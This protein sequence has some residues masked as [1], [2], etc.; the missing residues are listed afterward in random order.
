MLIHFFRERIKPRID[1]YQLIDGYFDSL[2]NSNIKSNDDEV[3]IT[4]TLRNFDFQYKFFVTKRSHIL[5]IYRLNSNYININLMCEVPPILPPYISRLIFKQISEICERFELAIYFEQLDN[6]HEFEMFELINASKKE[7]A[8]YLEKNPELV[9]YHLPMNVLN[10]MCH[11]QSMIDY[12]PSLVRSDVDVRKYNITVEKAT[13]EVKV[14]V[15][16]KVGTPAIFPPHL[17]YVQ[18][19]E[20]ENLIVLVPIEVFYKYVDRLMYEI[21]DDSIDFKLF[22]LNEKGAIKAKKLLRKMRDSVVSLTNFEF[23]KI[24][25]LIES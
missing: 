3:E 9:T 4:M 11:Y 7:L 19:E 15:S 25:D 6:I 2:D 21:K 10:E 5:S 17:D 23:I 22:Y 1:F 18:I 13:N 14:G 24:T 12:L 20:E 8:E 16:W